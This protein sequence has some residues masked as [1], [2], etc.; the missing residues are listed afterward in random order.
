MQHQHLTVDINDPDQVE[1][2]FRA[3]DYCHANPGADFRTVLDTLL[4]QCPERIRALNRE[5]QRDREDEE[6]GAWR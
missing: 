2:L 5:A 4:Q 1:A 6:S 3:R